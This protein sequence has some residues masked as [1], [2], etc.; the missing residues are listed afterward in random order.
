LGGYILLK[1][2]AVKVQ[3]LIDLALA[4]GPESEV[5][6]RWLL[7]SSSKLDRR[8]AESLS[9]RIG[10][11]GP[12]LRF[13]VGNETFLWPAEIPVQTMLVFLSELFTPAH[14]HQYLWGPTQI[15][16]SDTLLDIGACEGA[17]AAYIAGKCKSVLAVEPSRTMCIL[18]EKQFEL[19]HLPS[20]TIEQ[21]L[22][23][24]SASKAF[25]VENASNPGASRIVSQPVEGAYEVPVRT[26]DELL[27]STGTKP[28]FIKCDA[29][30][31]AMMIFSGGQKFLQKKKPK[32][33][34]AS[35]HTDSEYSC[36]YNLLK[37][38]GYHI[39]GKGFLLSGKKLRVQMLHAWA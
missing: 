16:A 13:E 32:L 10:K 15:D 25:F 24:E 38:M 30:G 36:L 21:C 20:P 31:A 6:K 34:I 7:H 18:I 2:L 8:F 11:S 17:F 5:D 3:A 26:L 19:R 14:P 4:S 29:E 9:Y 35:Y 12:Y 33:A 23:G 28:T 37:P 1:H 27:E 39:Q 22:L